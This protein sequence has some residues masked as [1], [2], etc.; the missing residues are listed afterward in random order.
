MLQ[1]TLRQATLAGAAVAKKYFDSDTLEITAKGAI[2]NWVTQADV[3]AEAA[4]KSVIQAQYPHH[5]FLGE[6]T[7][8]SSN[9][10]AEYKWIIDPIDG[11]VN[12]ASG[13]PLFTV[14]IALEHKGQIILA[15]VFN[16]ILNEWFWAEKGQG[17]FLNDKPIKVSTN[18]DIKNARLTTGTPSAFKNFENSPA[19][20]LIKFAN[21]GVSTRRLG[22]GSVHLCWTACGR[23]DCTYDFKMEPWDCAA[24]TLIVQEA[25]GTVT[26]FTGGPF[27]HYVHGLIASNGHIHQAV[28]NTIHAPNN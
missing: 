4:I 25:G 9:T 12:Y 18:T 16:P 8:A 1:Q 21:L 11:T 26:N 10:E 7:G 23:Y 19:K 17:A 6:E 15:S 5:A 27:N 14:C 20:V 3:E 28:L 13:I 2:N 22:S 24:G